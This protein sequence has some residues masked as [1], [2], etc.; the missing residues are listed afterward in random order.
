MMRIVFCGTPQFAVPTLEYLLAQN[1]FEIVGVIYAADRAR[2][3]GHEVSFS[4][5]KEA[6]LA[7]KLS[8]HQRRRFG[9]PKARRCCGIWL[10]IAS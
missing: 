5:V 2:G 8:V 1:D 10:P 6:A 4:A 7:A 9:R 3:R